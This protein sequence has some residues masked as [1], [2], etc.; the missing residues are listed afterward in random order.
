MPHTSWRSATAATPR[1]CQS[2]TSLVARHGWHSATTA[3]HLNPS[4]AAPRGYW[5][6]TCTSGRAPSGCAASTCAMRTGR[7]SGRPTAITYMGIHGENSATQ[8]TDL[9]MLGRGIASGLW[10]GALAPDREPVVGVEGSDHG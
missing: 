5:C 2:R 4:T 1:T 6:P 10:A 7:V 3:S 8:A 9:A